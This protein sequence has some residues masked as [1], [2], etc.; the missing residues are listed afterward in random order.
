MSTQ[1]TPLTADEFF[2]LCRKA[3]GRYELLRGEVVELSPVNEEH[4][5]VAFNISGAFFVYSRTYEVGRGGV[6][7]G[8]RLSQDPD[9]VRGPDVSFNLRSQQAEDPARPAFVTGATDLGIL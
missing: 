5:N 7:T 8:Y 9:S 1:K 4:G 6:E 2:L 3:E